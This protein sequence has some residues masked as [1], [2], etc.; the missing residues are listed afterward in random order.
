MFD[1][2]RENL[3]KYTNDFSAGG[4]TRLVIDILLFAAII[5]FLIRYV[6]F[7]YFNSSLYALFNFI[8]Y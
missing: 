8:L 5:Y 3:L 1:L 7:L 2:F 6:Y 4:V